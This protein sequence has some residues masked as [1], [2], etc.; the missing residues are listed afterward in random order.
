MLSPLL[1][2]RLETPWGGH[3]PPPLS[4]SVALCATET[5]AVHAAGER[6][7]AL[8]ALT[9]QAAARWLAD[10]V[11]HRVLEDFY[12]VRALLAADE[13][14]LAL[15]LR[16][17]R[18]VDALAAEVSP[19]VREASVAAAG[20]WAFW[21]KGVIDRHYR[22]AFALAHLL[23]A[24]SDARLVA[25]ASPDAAPP[26]PD[27]IPPRQPLGEALRVLAP[28]HS[29]GVEWRPSPAGAPE[30]GPT[31]L[32]DTM[33]RAA[34][35]LY[36]LL[37]DD[38]PRALLPT[39]PG[40]VLHAG[41]YDVRAVVAELDRRGVAT[42]P[43][44]AA[45]AGPRAHGSVDAGAWEALLRDPLLG[46]PFRWCG[47]DLLPAA[48]AALG[49]WWHEVVPALVAATTRARRRFARR[50]PAALLVFSPV[51]VADS[52]GLR[53]ARSLGIPTVTCQ[54]GGFEGN[55]EYTTYDLTDM[56]QADHRLTY[57]EG[58]GEYLARRA[59]RSEEPLAEVHAVGSARLDDLRHRP[60][61]RDDVR[62]RLG[63]GSEERLVFYLPGCYQHRS[64][65][66]CRGAY[67]GTLYLQL[68]EQ[69][70]A[71]IAAHPGVRVV[72]KP[73]PESPADPAVALL[74]AVPNVTVTTT[75]RPPELFAAADA[76]VL[77]IPSTA[78]LEAL[79]T[80]QRLLVHCDER[81][82]T[83]VPAARDALRARAALTETPE[84]FLAALDRVLTDPEGSLPPPGDREFLRR[85][86]THA[87]DGR[88]AARAAD[89]VLDIA[90]G[91]VRS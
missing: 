57:G 39:R 16:W 29:A 28:L 24:A 64:W 63:V 62:R 7:D 78:L 56:R 19:R 43:L 69:V 81:F 50:R 9:P 35:D 45:L 20:D 23:L 2:D 25:Y 76:A 82:V 36:R 80:P 30:A 86:G 8:V 21:L 90:A 26:G 33:P 68:L 41:G 83:L 58:I 46:E 89:V 27:L 22:A 32:R 17:V 48:L 61:S 18:S 15:Q 55:C 4:G 79:L 5:E 40:A 59:R 70:T 37:R 10:G 42:R 77:D 88:S 87:D 14:M 34:L 60:A 12:D 51:T 52:A 74:R 73:F 53:A 66:L 91:Q 3:R 54:H 1:H 84:A 72:Y 31:R 6:F 47:A 11:G 44:A 85:Y 71:T 75:I 38:G 67:L 49:V 65:Y 13:P